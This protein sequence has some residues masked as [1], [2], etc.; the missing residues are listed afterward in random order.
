M[1][2]TNKQTKNKLLIRVSLPHAV[3]H[4]LD[5]YSKYLTPLQI[6]CSLVEDTISPTA[7]ITKLLYQRQKQ[8]WA[9]SMHS[10]LLRFI[11]KGERQV[12]PLTTLYQG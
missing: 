2:V 8:A 4:Q 9:F 11:Q 7:V 12:L 1:I 3:T 5:K 6:L 10:F